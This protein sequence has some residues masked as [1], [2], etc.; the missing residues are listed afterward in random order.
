MFE[1]RIFTQQALAAYCRE[2]PD[3]R[4]ALQNW[5][6][7]VKRSKWKSFADVKKSFRTVDY[8]GNQ[9]C[10]FNLKG[11]D[12]RLVAVIKYTIGF[13]YIRFVGSHEEYEGIDCLTV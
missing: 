2:F 13:V 9:R 11:N 6:V 12:F 1:M 7:V 5:K 8:I 10:V 3:A 4:V